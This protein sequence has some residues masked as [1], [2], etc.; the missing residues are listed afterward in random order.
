MQFKF[1]ADFKLKYYAA[2]KGPHTGMEVYIHIIF[3][4]LRYKNYDEKM[5]DYIYKINVYLHTSGL[6]ILM[7][8]LFTTRFI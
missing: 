1:E 2:K 8:Y 3:Y 5:Y 6:Q 7:F 4:I